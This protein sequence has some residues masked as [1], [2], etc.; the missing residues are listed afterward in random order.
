MRDDPYRSKHTAG[1][2]HWDDAACH[3]LE[4]NLT[5]A[6]E[7]TCVSGS[8][9]F[10]R[11]N[12]VWWDLWH[13]LHLCKDLHCR[14]MWPPPR[15]CLLSLRVDNFTAS[16]ISLN[17]GQAYNGCFS[18]SQRTQWF[19]KSVYEVTLRW[20]Y[21]LYCHQLFLSVTAYDQILA[22]GKGNILTGRL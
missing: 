10:S 4:F 6:F 15:Q 13:F 14:A 20:F 16:V 12:K 17:L 1:Q 5:A 2:D 11:C 21:C 3:E 7:D 18:A 8:G 9:G 19:L 22:V